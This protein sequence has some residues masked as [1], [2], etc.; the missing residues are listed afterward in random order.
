MKREKPY[1]VYSDDPS[2]LDALDIELNN[3]TEKIETL[4]SRLDAIESD[5]WVTTGRIADEAVTTG[6]IAD[7]AVTGG[8]I[9]PFKDW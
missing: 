6:K 8:K 5:N 7:D 3:L 2:G 1:I 4:E 9:A